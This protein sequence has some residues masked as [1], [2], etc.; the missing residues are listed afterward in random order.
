MMNFVNFL[1]RFVIIGA[2]ALVCTSCQYLPVLGYNP[3]QVIPVEVSGNL[4]DVAFTDN[5]NHGWIVGSDAA[6]LETTNG[7]QSWEAKELTLDQ[8]QV[9]LTSVS[10]SGSEGW[11]VGEPSIL[12][13]TT[14][15]GNTWNQIT[16]SAQLPGSPYNIVALGSESAEM[17]T[18]LGAIYRTED[19]GLHWKALVEEAVGVVRNVSRAQDGRYMTVSA[20]GNFYSTWTPGEKAWEPHNRYSSKRLENMGFGKDGRLWMLGRGGE[21][22]FTNPED[23]QEWGEALNPEF[24]TSWGFLDLAYRTPKEIWIGGGSGN[25]LCSFDGGESWFKDEQVQNVPGNFNRIKFITP[26]KGFI[27][28]QRG[29]LLRY[30][31]ESSQAA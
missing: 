2:V 7:G 29:T 13:H 31:K 10:F 23:S 8:E 21:I 27:L 26:E 16:L 6:L 5:P 1:R 24:A 19:G 25:L 11:I 12:L 22:R 17:V 28:G 4:Y 15:E 14:D 18:D 3:W 20:K 30:T 9:R